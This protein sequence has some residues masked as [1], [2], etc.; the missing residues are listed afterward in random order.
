M[1]VYLGISEKDKSQI[2]QL[3][4]NLAQIS[5]VINVDK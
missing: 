3:S 4:K 2:N 5:F 1:N